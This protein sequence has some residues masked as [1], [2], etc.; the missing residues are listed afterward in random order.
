MHYFDIKRPLYKNC[1][2]WLAVFIPLLIASVMA[3]LIS[4]ANRLN[5]FPSFTL[6][7]LNNFFTYQKFPLAIFSLIFPSIGLVVAAHRSALTIQQ[8]QKIDAQIQA[9]EIQ[10]KFAN[11]YKHR[12]EFFKF[13]DMLEKTF[14]VAFNER[15]KLY[16]NLYPSNRQENLDVKSH[17]G[18]DGYLMIMH[19][20][21]EINKLVSYTFKCMMKLEEFENDPKVST[22]N[23]NYF[24]LENFYIEL[25]RICDKYLNFKP[26]KVTDEDK[27][28]VKWIQLNIRNIKQWDIGIPV[29]DNNPLHFYDDVCSIFDELLIF[30]YLSEKLEHLSYFEAQVRDQVDKQYSILAH[31]SN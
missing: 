17:P 15:N 19:F 31:S 26:I 10:N 30:T 5:Y 25:I 24:A 2:T 20:R 23:G 16:K 13:L 28:N 6:D 9:T 22:G 18:K 8:M 29:K 3:G 14:N 4:N 21:S 27:S 12:E 1:W 7:A 11:Y